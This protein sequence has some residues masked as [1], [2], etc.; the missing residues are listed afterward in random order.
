[1]DR[2]HPNIGDHGFRGYTTERVAVA[3]G[4]LIISHCGQYNRF[5]ARKMFCMPHHSR[6]PELT[7]AAYLHVIILELETVIGETEL[8]LCRRVIEHFVTD[9]E[10]QRKRERHLPGVFCI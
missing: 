2:S 5:V 4:F 1:M 6:Q 9:E 7:P 8:Q 3:I 10:S